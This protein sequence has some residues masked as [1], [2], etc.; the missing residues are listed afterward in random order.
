MAI[1]SSFSTE[2]N[3]LHGIIIGS[4]RD[5]GAIIG[6]SRIDSEEPFFIFDATS[7]FG[8]NMI[9]VH[10]EQ[11]PLFASQHIKY[12]G[13][14]VLALVGP[15]LEE[16]KVRAR[17]IEIEYQNTSTSIPDGQLNDHSPIEYSFGDLDL[18]SA[19]NMTSFTR[20]YTDKDRQT[21]DDM[22]SV[23]EAWVENDI[24]YVKVATQWP[25]HV[26]DCV[27]QTCSRT[28]KSVVIL[29]EGHYSKHDEKLLDPSILSSVAAISALHTN[30]RVKIYS[31]EPTCK[32]RFTITRETLLDENQKPAAEKVFVTVDQGAYPLFSGEM[33]Q[34]MLAGLLPQYPVKAFHCSIRIEESHKK[35]AHF[36]GTLGYTSALFSSEAHISSLAR[37]LKK[38]PANWRMS[39]YAAYPE[40]EQIISTLDVRHLK[41]LVSDVCEQSDFAR[42]NAVYELQGISKKQSLSTF[43]NYSRGI[44]IACGPGISGFNLN[45]AL[46]RDSKISI[47][48][49]NNS[50]TINSSFYLGEKTNKLWSTIISQEL[51]VDPSI[52]GSVAQD[53]SS[54]V[55]TGPEVL[56]LDVERSTAM[57]R[58]ICTIIKNK[59]FQEPLPIT[60]SVSAKSMIPTS[61]TRFI[62]SSW[63]CL[64]LELEV[65]TITLK[66]LVRRVVAKIIFS[67]V[68]NKEQLESKFRHVIYDVLHELDLI[69]FYFMK[70]PPLI[71][72]DIEST[73]EGNLPSSATQT[74]KAMVYSAYT[75]AFSQAL[76]KDI[77]SIPV[78][79]DD[80]IFQG[81]EI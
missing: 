6:Y 53:T 25:F 62:S 61:Q 67:Y 13:E 36:F 8:S 48:F 45:S 41:D 7:V 57:I 64:T 18:F 49:D 42:H 69:D 10:N 29:N 68:M 5:S 27:A 73:G 59:R 79:S 54:M 3:T 14:P 26:L 19:E 70:E 24:L 78:T 55:D 28:K 72:I 50:I 12:S 34:Q 76:G 30:K 74:V 16:V 9:T 77:T 33:I 20:T 71:E 46:H 58:Q 38:N 75:A 31:Q 60:A 40:K 63:G 35:P 80:I 52:I 47:T 17:Q 4:S 1:K 43:L 32:S 23:A 65:N 37:H 21:R 51:S 66:A 15:S 39:N 11:L 56:S 22:P 81:G 2:Q 44:G